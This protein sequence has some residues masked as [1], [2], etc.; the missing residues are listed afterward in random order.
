MSARKPSFI[1][2]SL[3]AALTLIL[4]A[5]AT[6]PP[7]TVIVKETVTVKETVEVQTTVEVPVEVTSIPEPA[8]TVKVFGAFATPLEE[9]WDNVIHTALVA[10]QERGEIEYTWADNIGYSG[11]MERVL[12]EEA[13]KNA[14]D[15]IFGDAFGNRDGVAKVAAEFPAIAFV[16]GSDGG[17]QNPNLAVF[18]NWIHEPAYLTGLI[19]GKMTETKHIG[20]VAAIPIPEVNRI[21]NAFIQGVKEANPDAKVTVSYIGGFFDPA[22]AKEA[23]LAMIDAGADII[24]AEREGG[25]EAAAE[26]G[27]FAFGSLTD[28]NA[29]APDY[30]LTSPLWN[31][32]PTVDYV[33]AQIKAGSYTAQ[34]LKDF[35]LMAKGGSSLAPYHG[36]DSKIPADVLD[37]VKQKQEAIISGNFRVDINEGAPPSGQ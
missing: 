27:L 34:D 35:S 9:P 12:R 19:A 29:E 10:A 1:V 17:P 3:I 11:D 2:I 23:T 14:P 37:L 24:Y 31:M 15:A 4:S 18:D 26:K 32:G 7:A 20:V 13:T 6:P 8:K 22:K 25:I 30:V 33:V 5:C 21:V 28:Q 36:N 16:F